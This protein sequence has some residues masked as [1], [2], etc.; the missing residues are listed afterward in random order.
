MKTEKD[1]SSD[2]HS[3]SRKES[4]LSQRRASIQARKDSLATHHV[5]P[6]VEEVA[7]ERNFS[8]LA[9]LGLAF[10]LLNSWTAMWVE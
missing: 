5:V 1:H 3:L 9:S 10:T 8:F 6:V 4:R 2:N 7:L